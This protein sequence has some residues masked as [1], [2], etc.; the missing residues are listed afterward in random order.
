MIP[1]I[2]CWRVDDHT[3][4]AEIPE[5][6]IRHFAAF[7]PIDP[8]DRKRLGYIDTPAETGDQTPPADPPSPQTEPTPPKPRRS[9]GGKTNEE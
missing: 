9:A 6:G 3:V 7:E 2:P 8:E 1:L 4:T 5:T